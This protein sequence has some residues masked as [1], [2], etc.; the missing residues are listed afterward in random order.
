MIIAI[1]IT[2]LFSVSRIIRRLLFFGHLF[3]LEGYKSG[4]YNIWLKNH[5]RDAVI[6]N[7]HLAGIVILAVGSILAIFS[8]VDFTMKS[9][10]SQIS[11][12]ALLLLWTLAFSRSTDFSRRPAAQVLRL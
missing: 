10:G 7:S 2:L 4:P 3:Q 6:R 12:L 9:P 11:L 5:L 1:I 8:G